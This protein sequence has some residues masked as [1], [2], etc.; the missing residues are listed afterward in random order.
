[1]AYEEFAY[2]YD[3]LNQA[4]DFD[5]LVQQLHAQLCLQGITS[6]IIADLGCGTGEVTLRLAKLGYDMIAIDRSP[7]ML[8]ILREK[9]EE[10]NAQNILLLNQDLT[11]LDLYGTIHGAVSTFD[12][13]N[14]LAKNDLVTAL[15]KVH[16]FMEPGGILL[17]DANTSYKHTHVLANNTF[18][19]SDP[20][21]DFFCQWEN[22]YLPQQ[23]ATEIKI[24][25]RQGQ[26]ILFQENFLE[27][28]Y[29]MEDWQEM[30]SSAG[31]IIAAVQDGESFSPLTPTSQRYL[32]T[33]R[34]PK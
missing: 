10:E 6:G 13:F 23:Q 25:A 3:D 12:T 11:Q 14:H 7:D 27:Y 15:E 19:F 26:E 28:E 34:K 29:T 2:W 1:M 5:G 32:F 9:A 31:F 30:L 8:S 24:T 20:E 22:K 17:F 16:L 18:E 33:A 4:A 21:D